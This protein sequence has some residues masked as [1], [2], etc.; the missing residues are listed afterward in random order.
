MMTNVVICKNTLN[1]PKAYTLK[2]VAAIKCECGASVWSRD[3]RGI[4]CDDCGCPA[5]TKPQTTKSQVKRDFTYARYIMG[6]ATRVLNESK[7]TDDP[8]L[9]STIDIDTLAVLANDL[10]GAAATLS[11]YVAERGGRL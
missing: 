4:F 1:P 2:Q 5:P 8:K 3:E 11:Q 9:G 6:L 7:G 10:Q